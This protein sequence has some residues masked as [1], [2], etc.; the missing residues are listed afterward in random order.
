[1]TEFPIP[2]LSQ[3]EMSDNCEKFLTL[4]AVAQILGVPLYA[5]R[6]AARRGLFP[7][8]HFGARRRLVRLSEVISAVEQQSARSRS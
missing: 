3:S 6:R 4:T 7:S 8:Y 2:A 5:V 1:M